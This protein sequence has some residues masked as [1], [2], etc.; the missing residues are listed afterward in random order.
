VTTEQPVPEHSTEQMGLIRGLGLKEATA[1]NVVEMVGIG[2]FITIPFLISAMNGPQALLGW[3]VGAVLAICDGLVWA[4]L[5]AAMPGAGGSYVYLREAFNPKR[6]GQLMGFLF[7]WMILFTA[8]LSAATGGVGFAEYLHYLVPS[9]SH[10]ATVGVAI[11]VVALVT[12]MVYRDIRSVGRL[13]FWLMLVVLSSILWVIVSGVFKLKI[14]LLTNFPPHA[15]SF[16]RPFFLGLGAASLIAIYGYGGYNNVCYLGAEVKQPS[17]NIPRAVILS[18]VVVAILYFFMTVSI[19]GVV[20]WKTAAVSQHVVSDFMELI[21]GH[22]AAQAITVLILGAAV[23]SLFALTLGM[24]RIPYAAAVEGQFFKPFAKL[25]PKGHFPTVSILTLGAL[26]A[27]FCFFDL[28]S[29]IQVLMV[30]QVI[31]LFLAQILAV[32]LIRRYRKDIQRPFQMWLYP[33]PSI[34]AAILWLLVLVSTGWKLVSI[35]LAV[36]ALGVG[37]YLL[38][39]RAQKQWPFMAQAA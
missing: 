33:L 18:I 21:Y 2:P 1:A 38:R 24:S 36:L 35:G 34:A 19:I 12:A 6:M 31:I 4:E 5:G 22:W 28:N 7:V 17:R 27:F 9:L 20:P 16:S 29:I 10:A 32:T 13:S 23:A 37:L 39:A 30:I 8:P 11:A 26:S 15:F 25:H 3:L 14:S